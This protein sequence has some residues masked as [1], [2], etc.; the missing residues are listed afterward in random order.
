MACLFSMLFCE[1]DYTLS[2]T[3]EDAWNINPDLDILL[4]ISVMC[5]HGFSGTREVFIQQYHAKKDGT[6]PILS[7]QG[8]QSNEIEAEE[9]A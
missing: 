5:T 1:L 3:I 9:G 8:E 6:L 2:F 7:M 4:E